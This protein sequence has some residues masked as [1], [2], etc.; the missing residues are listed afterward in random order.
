MN[1]DQNDRAEFAKMI[2]VMAENFS[3]DVSPLGIESRFRALMDFPL[4]EVRRGLNYLIRTR[5]YS[6]M[7]TIGEMRDAIAG[8]PTDAA[9]IQASLVFET[10]RNVG[11]YRSVAFDDPITVAVIRR[12]FGGWVRACEE[13]NQSKRHF[14]EKEFESAYLAFHRAGIREG[15]I[16]SGIVEADNSSRGYVEYIRDPALIGDPAGV[17]SVL[18]MGDPSG[19]VPAMAG[20]LAAK[21]GHGGGNR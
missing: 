4:V 15:G 10:I 14:F 5:R 21:I 16:L 3:A 12:R 7:P 13:A 8:S 20:N 11:A 17:R 18:A 19:N 1:D 6:T 2:A 9:L